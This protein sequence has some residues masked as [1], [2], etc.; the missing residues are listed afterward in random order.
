MQTRSRLAFVLTIAAAGKIPAAAQNLGD[1]IRP[2]LGLYV[3]D[4]PQLQFQLIDIFTDQ[5]GKGNWQGYFAA[6]AQVAM[7]PAFRRELRNRP[8]VVRDR[9]LAFRAGY[10]RQNTVTGGTTAP[11]NR[12]IIELTSRYQLPW[13]IVAV[14]RNRGEF[15]FIEGKPFSTRYRNRLRFERDFQ[16]GWLNATPYIYDEIFYDTRYSLWTPNR[17]GFGTEFPIGHHVVVD[18]YYFRQ[19]GSRSNPPLL[20]VFGLRLNLFL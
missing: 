19:H 4:G 8:D 7:K 9:Y 10:Q 5:L 13:K 3:Q 15:R 18:P 2:E 16:H 12:G 6:Y 20:N 1:E 17:F 11:E 14:D